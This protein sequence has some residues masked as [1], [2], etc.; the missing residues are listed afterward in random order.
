M[1]LRSV[2]LICGISNFLVRM[3]DETDELSELL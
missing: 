1:Y 2:E 3:E